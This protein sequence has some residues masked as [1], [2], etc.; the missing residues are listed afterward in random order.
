MI[1]CGDWSESTG[2]IT[3][4]L[5]FSAIVKKIDAKHKIIIA[6][7]H[8]RIAQQDS[9]LVKQIFKEANAIYLQDERVTINGINFWGSPWSVE[10]NNWAFMLPDYELTRKWKKIPKDTD[11]LITHTPP[12]GILDCLPNI[13]NV[14]SKTLEEYVKKIRPYIHMFG[15]IHSGYGVEHSKYTDFYNVSICDDDY[16]I[17]NSPTVINI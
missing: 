17:K 10:F 12:Y 15:H 9:L 4:V 11:V 16:N 3:D 1:F 14:G 8:D 6:G 2:S 5:K 7:N 13:G